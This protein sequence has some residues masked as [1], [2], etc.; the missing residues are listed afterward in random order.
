MVIGPEDGIAIVNVVGLYILEVGKG[1]HANLVD[2]S[3]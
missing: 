2:R 3:N 1:V